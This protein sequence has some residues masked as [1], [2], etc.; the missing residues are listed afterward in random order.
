MMPSVTINRIAVKGK[1]KGKVHPVT[2]QE[3]LEVE[4]GYNSTLSLTSALD[5]VGWSTPNPGCFTAGKDP[6]PI[7]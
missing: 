3:D 1:G 4:Y 6:M 5:V 2:R 7:V